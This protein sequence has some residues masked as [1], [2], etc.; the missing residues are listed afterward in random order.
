MR[1]FWKVEVV[2]QNTI[3]TVIA[4]T[5]LHGAERAQALESH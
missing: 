5:Q 1:M 4:C 3:V 2:K